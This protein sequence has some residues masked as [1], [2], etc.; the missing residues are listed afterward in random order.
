M[1]HKDINDKEIT[2]GSVVRVV[3]DGLKAYQIN[4]KG[5]GSFQDKQFVPLA[6]G[7]E[8][9]TKN[10]QIPVG[11]AGKVMKVYNVEDISAHT[12]IQVKFEPGQYSDEYEA[13][14]AFLMHF[15]TYELEIVEWVWVGNRRKWE[16]DKVV[17]A[18]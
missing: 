14:L 5:F 1:E 6:P 3:V 15:H 13:P 4:P 10:L 9:G 17:L 8:R 7:G 2:V 18:S 12:P 16:S 11:L